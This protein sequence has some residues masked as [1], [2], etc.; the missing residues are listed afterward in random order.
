M[1][2]LV[3]VINSQVFFKINSSPFSSFTIFTR[4]PFSSDTAVRHLSFP[5][6]AWCQRKMWAVSTWWMKTINTCANELRNRPAFIRTVI[7]QCAVACLLPVIL[8]SSDVSCTS[9]GRDEIRWRSTESPEAAFSS[10]CRARINSAVWGTE[11]M[12]RRE[13]EGREVRVAKVAERWRKRV[14]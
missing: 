11:R 8:C 12:I 6:W 4:R 13:G 5:P 1:W 2:T 9:A 14:W 7:Q 10:S 3:F